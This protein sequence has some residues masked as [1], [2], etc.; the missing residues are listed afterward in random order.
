[1][2]TDKIIKNNIDTLKKVTEE[3]LKRVKDGIKTVQKIR[4]ERMEQQY[5]SR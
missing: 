4:E 2:S 3:K 1:M 5:Q